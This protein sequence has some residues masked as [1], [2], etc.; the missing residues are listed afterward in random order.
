MKE[1]SMVKEFGPISSSPVK[2]RE[3]NAFYQGEHQQERAIS[4]DQW[5]ISSSI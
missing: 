3:E 4:C 5:F 2:Y 1:K